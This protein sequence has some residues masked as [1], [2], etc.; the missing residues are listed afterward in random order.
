MLVE[1]SVERNVVVN[2]AHLA[3]F[4]P[5]AD[6][7]VRK[8]GFRLG[9]LLNQALGPQYSVPNDPFSLASGSTAVWSPADAEI[10]KEPPARFLRRHGRRLWAGLAGVY[11]TFNEPARANV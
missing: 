11:E 6:E 5:V 10:P 8:G 9:R 7:R 1:G 4:A 2:Q 3:V